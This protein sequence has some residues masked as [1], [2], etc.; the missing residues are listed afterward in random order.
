VTGTWSETTDPKGYYGGARYFGSI[1]MLVELTG[2]RMAGKWV[3]FGKN[4]DV[5][6]G[7]W[8]LTLEDHSTSKATIEA[9]NRPPGE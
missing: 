3:G 9:Y 8:E 6:S 7:P 5:N 1:Q 2:R 4:F